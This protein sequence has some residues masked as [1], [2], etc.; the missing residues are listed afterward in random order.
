MF[1]F[2]NAYITI[3][4]TIALYGDGGANGFKFAPDAANAYAASLKGSHTFVDWVSAK[5]DGAQLTRSS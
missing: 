1:S 4:Y 2:S 3:P 5:F